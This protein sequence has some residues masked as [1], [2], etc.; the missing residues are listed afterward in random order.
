[1]FDA[2]HNWYYDNEVWM[3]TTWLG[4]PALKSVQDMWSYQEIITDLQP[5]LIVE[6]GV[7]SGGSSLYFA[8]ILDQLGNGVVLG[9]DITLEN[10]HDKARNHPRIQLMESSSTCPEVADRIRSLRRGP[11]FAVL[12][13]DHKKDH[14]VAELTTLTPILRAGDY[15]IVEDSNINGHPIL[16]GWGP[17]P[18][19]AIEEY[20]AANPQSYRQ[21][22]DRENKFGWTFAP[23]GFL[24]R[25]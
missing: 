1:M 7:R 16:P 22:L 25:L 13:S 23:A 12:D 11:V 21:D 2:Y 3:T 8:S 15:V 6:F 4:V 24:I 17:G 19:E 14:V 18:Y 20:L 9:V 5:D 10:V